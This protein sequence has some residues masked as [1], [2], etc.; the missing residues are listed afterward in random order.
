MKLGLPQVTR[1]LHA[2]EPDGRWLTLYLKTAEAACYAGLFLWCFI[3]APCTFSAA[4]GAGLACCAVVVFCLRKQVSEE[5][6]LRDVLRY[7]GV[8]RGLFWR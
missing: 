6:K 3:V 7:L 8:S 4:V 1:A 5:L 2:W